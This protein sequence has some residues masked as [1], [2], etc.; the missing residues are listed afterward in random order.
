M[1]TQETFDAAVHAQPLDVV[2]VTCVPPPAAGREAE[3]PDKVKLHDEKV[4]GLDTALVPVPMGPTAA[5]R[6]S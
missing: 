1:A 4:K 3:V 6:A 5:T 2:T